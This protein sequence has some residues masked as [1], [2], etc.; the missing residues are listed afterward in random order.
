[1]CAKT[2]LG[3]VL[4]LLAL[5]LPTLSLAQAGKTYG[6]AV[7]RLKGT[8]ISETEAETLSETFHT[9][10]SQIIE[11]QGAK[12][13]EKY[14]LLER[15]QMDKILETYQV[16]DCIDVSCA[17]DLGKQLAV[18]RIIVGSVGLVGQTYMITD[19]SV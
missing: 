3:A 13:K 16:Q 18:D 15:S 1:M 6:L 19:P 5:F 7:M 4:F 17:V 8:G 11:E 2:S 10:I 9:G 14:S 12:L